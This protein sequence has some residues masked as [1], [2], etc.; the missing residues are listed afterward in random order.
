LPGTR[1]VVDLESAA[2]HL[3]R[4]ADLT[5]RLLAASRWDVV[6]ADAGASD[7][8]QTARY[9]RERL[10]GPLQDVVPPRALTFRQNTPRFL[11][12]DMRTCVRAR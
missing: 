12:R 5:L 6:I 1:A 3:R 9:V 7:A 4:E 8:E 11:A 2:D 10:R